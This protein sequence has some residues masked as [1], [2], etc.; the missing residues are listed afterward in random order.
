MERDELKQLAN[1]AIE[2]Y[3][4]CID[5]IVGSIVSKIVDEHKIED[6]DDIDYL[7]AKIRH[8]IFKMEI[9]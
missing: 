6:E 7:K 9:N 3:L 5:L 1:E 4:Q 8:G 2:E